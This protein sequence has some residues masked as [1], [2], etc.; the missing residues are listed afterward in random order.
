MKSTHYLIEELIAHA[1]HEANCARSFDS[2]DGFE[3]WARVV[4]LAMRLQERLT[5]DG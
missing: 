1:N 5:E 2:A 4:T 3:S